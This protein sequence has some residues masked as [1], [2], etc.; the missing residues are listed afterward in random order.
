MV[1][2]SS[3]GAPPSPTGG[4]PSPL[5]EREHELTW[6]LRAARRRPAVV[7][8]EG[9]AGVGKTRLVHEL[10]DRAE[11]AD[12]RRLLGHCHPLREPFPF[13]PV[14]EA[15]SRTEPGRPPGTLP[16]I[17][18]ALRELLPEL[19]HLLPP[20]PPDT[21][22]PRLRRH[23]TFRAVRELLAAL[24]PAVLVLE[25]VHWMDDGTRELVC[26]LSHEPPGELCLVLTARPEDA[27]TR[28]WDPFGGGARVRALRLDR[29]S[30]AAVRHLAATLLGVDEVGAA[31]ATRLHER[32]GGLPLAVV[33]LLH[34]L[35]ATA[36]VP[37]D[38]DRLAVPPTMQAFLAQRRERLSSAG[39]RIVDAAA[40][41]G[42]PAEERV[43]TAVAGLSPDTGARGLAEA[44]GHGVLGP[45]VGPGVLGPGVPGHGVPRPA[46]GTRYGFHH[47]LAMDAA[48]EAI[49]APRRQRLHDRA[50]RTLRHQRPPPHARLARHARL[51]GRAVAA[52]RHAE[53]AADEAIR[54]GDNATA[55]TLLRTLL[56]T[57]ELPRATRIRLVVKLARAATLGLAHAEVVPLLRQVLATERLPAGK[58]GEI[59][60]GLGL[61]LC[62]QA[63]DADAGIDQIRRAATE[64][65]ARPDLAVRA[66]SA[67]AVPDHTPGPVSENLRA[68]RTATRLLPRVSDPAVRTAVLVNRASTLLCIGDPAGWQ[69]A[70]Q[71]PTTGRSPAEEQQLH[72][73]LCN[74]VTNC[75]T[76]G[77]Y[78][79]AARFLARART[80]GDGSRADYPRSLLTPLQT[81][82]DFAV[83]RWPPAR[84][85]A[86]AQVRSALPAVRQ[87]A[88]M[89]L[90]VFALIDGDPAEARRRI[91]AA[92]PEPV[93][94]WRLR[95]DA[96]TVGWLV[97]VLLELG[98]PAAA[99]AQ[100]RPLLAAI[101]IKDAWVWAAEL[102]PPVVDA[103]LA[104]GHRDE[105]GALVAEFAGGVHGRDA[106]LSAAAVA[107]CR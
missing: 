27:P 7:L 49:A 74:L 93:S 15:L 17:T 1:V 56:D 43:L 38:I 25:D 29:L 9:E 2:A 106:P 36:P 39:R 44:L 23:R 8:V 71:L 78:D 54:L 87:D 62:N 48:Y 96:M 65:R 16:A 14:V 21:G 11:L 10:L 3:P 72:R 28:P 61:M 58:R 33:E 83:G 100:A 64:L 63:V 73:G 41:L 60:L 35:P 6:L 70:E 24:G 32:T 12:A 103:L 59:R 107:R 40:V 68:L 20:A 13:G 102:V 75:L 45:G 79:R 85:Q 4:G 46:D 5:V 31:F 22:D 94:G 92:C 97:T 26:Y 88:S 80:A 30:P 57:T 95:T 101:G 104:A 82:L 76:L 81:H 77:H 53:R 89:L 50:E 99:L 19:A 47:T 91:L 69:A 98:R 18:G 67:L 90:G 51:A 37:A 52:Y 84:R 86:L 34:L 42:V 55:T 105:A 66:L